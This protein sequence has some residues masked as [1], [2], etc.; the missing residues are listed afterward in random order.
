[1]GPKGDQGD[2]G[3]AGVGLKVTFRRI[4]WCAGFCAAGWTSD[5]RDSCVQGEK[6]EPGLVIGPD[7]NLLNLEGLQGP[8]VSAATV[9]PWLCQ[10]SMS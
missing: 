2:P 4:S 5:D 8:K 9:Q 3:P 6:G 1:M 7:G 10:C